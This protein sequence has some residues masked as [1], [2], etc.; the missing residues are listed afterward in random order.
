MSLRNWKENW[1]IPLGNFGNNTDK[2]V[3]HMR[4]SYKQA[5]QI[6]KCTIIKAACRVCSRWIFITQSCIP[7]FVTCIICIEVD[8]YYHLNAQ[9]MNS[10]ILKLCKA[11]LSFAL[12]FPFPS[13]LPF[14]CLQLCLHTSNH[15]CFGF[16]PKFI[17]FFFASWK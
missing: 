9:T 15:Y 16:L 17:F 2:I 12:A 14:L 13:T 4:I 7:F 6:K 3:E 1:S 10:I 11:S 8:I 5:L